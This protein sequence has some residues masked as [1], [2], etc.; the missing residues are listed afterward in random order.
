MQMSKSTSKSV[1]RWSPRGFQTKT[2]YSFTAELLPVKSYT[3][4]SV[5]SRQTVNCQVFDPPPPPPTCLPFTSYRAHLQIIGHSRRKVLFLIIP[6]IMR[7]ELFLNAN[8]RTAAVH[9]C[10]SR[11][12]LP[13]RLVTV[14]DGLQLIFAHLI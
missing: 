3:I 1:V 13:F 7:F 2:R 10:I 6:K 11:T 14:A 9:L 8:G 12:L 5:K 4:N